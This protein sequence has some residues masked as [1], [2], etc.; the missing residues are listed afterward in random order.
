MNFGCEHPTEDLPTLVLPQLE[1]F[2]LS[3][4]NCDRTSSQ[5][6]LPNPLSHWWKVLPVADSFAQQAFHRRQPDSIPSR[7]VELAIDFAIVVRRAWFH[8]HSI[9]PAA[10]SEAMQ[11]RLRS[12]ESVSLERMAE[13]T[14]LVERGWIGCHPPQA[15]ARALLAV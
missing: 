2:G 9:H 14:S 6:V 15:R 3:V 8:R 13:V 11:A 1:R 7:V 4:T 5:L 10:D 12:D